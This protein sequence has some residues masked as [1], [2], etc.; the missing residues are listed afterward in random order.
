MSEAWKDPELPPRPDRG[1]D[2]WDHMT[3]YKL[4]D[5]LERFPRGEVL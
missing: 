2:A 5:P 4:P 3:I 1:G